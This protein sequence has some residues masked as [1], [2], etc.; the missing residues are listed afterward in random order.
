MKAHCKTCNL[1]NETSQMQH[2]SKQQ[3][4]LEKVVKPA[5]KTWEL[6]LYKEM[7][8]TSTNMFL[9]LHLLFLHYMVHFFKIAVF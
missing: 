1:G 5:Q 4:N 6:R 2:K 7:S 8:S 9:M 3:I